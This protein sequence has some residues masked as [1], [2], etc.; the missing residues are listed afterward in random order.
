QAGLS[1]ETVLKKREGFRKAF[2]GFDYDRVAGYDGRKIRNLLKNKDIIR[3]RAK[4]EAAIANSRAFVKVRREEGSFDAYVWGLVGGKPK[5]NRWRKIHHIPSIT[6]ESESMS[7]DLKKRGFTFVGPTICYAF[8]QAVGM[9][10]DHLVS[11]FRYV[12]VG[13]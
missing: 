1:W 7:R 11:C 12:E 8:M 2:N 9:V 6:P 4:V 5:K 3:N 13:G 10:N